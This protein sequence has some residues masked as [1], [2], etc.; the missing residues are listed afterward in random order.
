MDETEW[1]ARARSFGRVAESYEQY[2][3]GYPDALVDHVLALGPGRRVLEAGAGTGLATRAFARRGAAVVA[4]EPDPDMAAVLRTRTADLD[5]QVV[6]SGFEEYRAEPGSADLVVAAQA[7]HW[8]DPARGGAVAARALAPGGSLAVWWNRP[9]ERTGPVW[10]AVDAAY[11]RL[12]PELRDRAHVHTHARPELT[13]EPVPGFG[14]WTVAHHDWTATADAAHYTGQLATFS[15][16]LRMEP[17][18]LERLLAGVAAAIEEH[19]GH[20]AL[21]SRTHL[22]HARPDPQRVS[23]TK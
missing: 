19:G 6:V 21:P 17:A 18:R 12:A 2:R 5:V 3:P 10:E 7:W 23:S 1:A 20:V 11:A 8:V 15:D 14:T 13:R 9:R 16:H 4:V 22:L